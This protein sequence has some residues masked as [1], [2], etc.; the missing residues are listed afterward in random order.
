MDWIRRHRPSPAMIVAVLALLGAF[1]G[2]A[3]AGDVVDSA[4]KKLISGSKI[5]KRSISG[6]RLK[7]NTVTGR[8]VA[9][10]KL[11]KVPSAT[12][13]DKATTAT[14]ATSASAATNAD[15][16][17]SKDSTAFLELGDAHA[18]GAADSATIDDFTA[19][20]Y[21][22]IVSKTFT[23]PKSGFVL[24]AGSVSTEDDLTFAGGG[25]LI[26]RLA[27]DGT[28]LTTDARYHEIG[29]NA[30]QSVFSGSG[31]TTAVVS[32]SAGSHTVSL[33]ARETAS[34][35]FI[36]GRDISVLFVRS[37]DPVSTPF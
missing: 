22:D 25:N 28:G 27:L 12:N 36:R 13:A 11:G 29:T 6:N 34:G 3:I 23:A 17:D 32:I 2:S 19:A 20:T 5:K 30:A 14:S 18:A 1:G 4:K 15:K 26:Y 10:S 24:I 35:D 21:T 37:G 33:Q 31:A 7:R 16:L 8:E 9:E